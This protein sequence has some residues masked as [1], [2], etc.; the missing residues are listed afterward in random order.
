M[1]VYGNKY[2]LSSILL[3]KEIELIIK[4]FEPHTLLKIGVF[5]SFARNEETEKAI[6]PFNMNSIILYL[7]SQ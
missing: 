1:H 5:G 3:S 6:L 7:Y 4:V 2:Y